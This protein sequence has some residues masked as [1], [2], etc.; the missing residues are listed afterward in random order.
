MTKMET[1]RAESTFGNMVRGLNVYGYE[2]LK[3]EALVDLYCYK[4]TPPA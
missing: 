3:G 1:L 2:V 4:T